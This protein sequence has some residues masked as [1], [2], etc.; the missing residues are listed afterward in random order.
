MSYLALL[1]TQ[2]KIYIVLIP[3]V[4]PVNHGNKKNKGNVTF[5]KFNDEFIEGNI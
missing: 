4:V 5:Q 1:F 2:G 3:L